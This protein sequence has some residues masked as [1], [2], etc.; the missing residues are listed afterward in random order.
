M[1]K[2]AAW[3]VYFSQIVSIQFHPA[4]KAMTMDYDAQFALLSRCADVADMMMEVE[5]CRLRLLER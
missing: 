5:E 4:N 3:R 2:V 1:D